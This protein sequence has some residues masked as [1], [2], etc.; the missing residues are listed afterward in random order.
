MSPS[1]SPPS[2]GGKAI[3]SPART[4]GSLERNQSL[5][6]SITLDGDETDE[7]ISRMERQASAPAPLLSKSEEGWASFEKTVEEGL[8]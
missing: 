3:T 7:P 2:I 1:Q 8:Y 6:T 4:S 5:P